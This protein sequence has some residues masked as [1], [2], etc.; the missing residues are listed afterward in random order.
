MVDSPTDLDI[1]VDNF[2]GHVVFR[3]RTY[4]ART[5]GGG[6]KAGSE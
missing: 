1:F 5:A 4:D 2:R 6:C 3:R